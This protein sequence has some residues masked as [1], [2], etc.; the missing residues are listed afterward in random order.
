MTSAPPPSEVRLLVVDDSAVD[1]KVLVHALQ[2][3][4]YSVT[5]VTGRSGD[6]TSRAR[7][8][9]EEL[10]RGEPPYD[11]CLLDVNMP[12]QTGFDL[13]KEIKSRPALRDV[14]VILISSDADERRIVRCVGARR[15]SRRLRPRYNVML[16]HLST[17]RYRLLPWRLPDRATDQPTDQ[18]TDRPTDRTPPPLPSPLQWHRARRFRLLRQA[19]LFCAAAEPHRGEPR[20][21]PAPPRT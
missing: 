17:R 11:A 13:L 15:K 4:G 21:A 20:A 2:R 6:A 19:D 1:C 12:G 5:G 10:A 3:A 8:C 18:T 14:V 16:S 9:L 7:E